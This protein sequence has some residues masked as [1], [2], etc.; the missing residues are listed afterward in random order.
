MQNLNV[1]GEEKVEEKVVR[2][3]SLFEKIN[4]FRNAKENRDKSVKPDVELAVQTSTIDGDNVEKQKNSSSDDANASN[5]DKDHGLVDSASS[6]GKKKK[7][8]VTISVESIEKSHQKKLMNKKNP[9]ATPP[10]STAI[11]PNGTLIR[12]PTR[13]K[14]HEKELAEIE[15][16]SI[17]R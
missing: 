10:G 12:S 11:S 15:K 5:K 16:L 7:N 14:R 9:I 13:K 17:M 8:K 6:P 3:R 1:G 4:P 2:S